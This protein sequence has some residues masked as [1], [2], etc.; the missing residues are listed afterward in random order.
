MSALDFCFCKCPKGETYDPK[1]LKCV[2]LMDCATKEVKCKRGTSQSPI[3]CNCHHNEEACK[4]EH[5]FMEWKEEKGIGLCLFRTI[6]K[7]YCE[8]W[9]ISNYDECKC[10]A[11]N[12]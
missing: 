8:P 7:I 5:P 11:I 10:E 3:D 1:D 9:T 6:C 12:N 4:K 2:K